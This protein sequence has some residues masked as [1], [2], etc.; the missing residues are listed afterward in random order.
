M[1]RTIVWGL[2]VTVLLGGCAQPLQQATLQSQESVSAD[3]RRD[4]KA[5]AHTL[6]TMV[7]TYAVDTNGDYPADL[8]V[9]KKEAEAQGYWRSLTNP[10]DRRLPALADTALPGGLTY[11]YDAGKRHYE[12][13]GWDATGQPVLDTHRQPFVLTND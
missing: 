4:V 13:T 1:G 12:I 10:V 5:N 2:A 8:D 11:R 3:Y 9:L 7:E 6:Q